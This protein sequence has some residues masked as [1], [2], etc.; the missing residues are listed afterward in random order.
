MWLDVFNDN[1]YGTNCWLLAAE[2]GDD[3]VV[4]DPGFEPPAR[5][6][7][8]S[9]P[10]ASGR[11]RS[12]SPTPTSTTRGRPG[13]S[14]AD[15]PVFVHEADAVAF[16]DRRAWGA[17]FAEPARA[18]VKDLRAV[19]DGDVLRV[20]GLL[21]RGDPHA[22]AHAR[23]LRASARTPG[24]LGRPGVRRLDRAVGLPELDPAAMHASLHRFL[25]LPDD[26][27]RAPR[28]TA[29]TPTVGRERATNPF[30]AGLG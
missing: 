30:L 23:P 10:R 26:A 5:A 7:R 29:R 12:C 1:A 14:P 17:G 4:V 28:A 9:T 11:S 16:T 13:T 2:D 20:R 18:P 8:C 22:R 6:R 21:A 15:L 27:P 24:V 25:T 19:A 3:A